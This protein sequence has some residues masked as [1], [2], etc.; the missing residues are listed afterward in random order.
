[1]EIILAYYLEYNPDFLFSILQTNFPMSFIKKIPSLMLHVVSII[2]W[3]VSRIW[4]YFWTFQNV[5]FVPDPFL[6]CF[7]CLGFVILCSLSWC[8]F[9][10]EFF[11]LFFNLYFFHVHFITRLSNFTS[12]SAQISSGVAL[13]FCINLGK[14]DIFTILNPLSHRSGVSLH[15]FSFFVFFNNI[16]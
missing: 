7:N 9:F 16:L 3:G 12:T 1:M 13:Y 2:K 6:H 11:F 14:I 5:L 4:V 15:Y 10:W 8:S